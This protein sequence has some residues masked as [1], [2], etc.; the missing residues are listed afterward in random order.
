MDLS[1]TFGD[2]RRYEIAYDMIF[3]NNYILK[4]IFNDNFKIYGRKSN[5]EINGKNKSSDDFVKNVTNASLPFFD[6]I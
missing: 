2:S 1:Q 3:F 5:A 4:D 6:F